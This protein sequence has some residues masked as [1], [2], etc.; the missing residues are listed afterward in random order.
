MEPKQY[1]RVYEGMREQFRPDDIPADWTIF[2]A[3]RPLFGT[4]TWRADFISGIF[5]GAVD[6]KDDRAE[7]WIRE[8]NKLDADVLVWVTIDE[9]RTAVSKYYAKH[10][11][12]LEIDIDEHAHGELV[13]SYQNAIDRGRID[14]HLI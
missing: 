8:N 10:Y 2:N 1:R 7:M 13:M 5:Y 9:V 14:D 11:P 4:Q 6:P 3:P 12:D